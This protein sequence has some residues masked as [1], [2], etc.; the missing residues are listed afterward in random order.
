MAELRKPNELNRIRDTNDGAETD[1]GHGSGGLKDPNPMEF[2]P[3]QSIKGPGAAVKTPYK[4]QSENEIKEPKMKV[5]GTGKEESRID[6]GYSTLSKAL[7]DG[8]TDF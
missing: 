1:S 5:V 7:K 6:H 8:E 4:E 2:Q 3:H